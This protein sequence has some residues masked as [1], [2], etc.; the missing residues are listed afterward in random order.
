MVSAFAPESSSDF[1]GDVFT[2]GTYD[3]AEPLHIGDLRL[4][5]APTAHY[6]P[7]FALRCECAGASVTYSADTAPSDDVARIAHECD[8]F[9]CEASLRSGDDDS[10][11]RGHLSAAEAGE[12]AQSAGVAKLIVTH[13]PHTLDQQTLEA[14]ASSSFAGEVA[15]ADDHAQYAAG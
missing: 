8:L 4:H 7:T 1:L 2:V 5:F 14:D 15:V 10:T 11:P 9:L 3:P 13:Y 12:I 6:I